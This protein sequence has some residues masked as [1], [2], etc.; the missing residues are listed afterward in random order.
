MEHCTPRN[1]SA[2]DKECNHA[3][4]S[5]TSHDKIIGAVLSGQRPFSWSTSKKIFTAQFGRAT[6]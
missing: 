6:P 4:P 5:I 1:V 3:L 2:R